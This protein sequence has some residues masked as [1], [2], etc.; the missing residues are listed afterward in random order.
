MSVT[1][2]DAPRTT[3]ENSITTLHDLP[4]TYLHDEV[5][6]ATTSF[7]SDPATANFALG[8]FC[9]GLEWDWQSSSGFSS[10]ID[11][12][13]HAK[14][15]PGPPPLSSDH[16]AAYALEQ[17]PD[18][19]KIVTPVDVPMF[20]HLLTN[21]PNRPF[22]NS[23]L[24]GLTEGFWPICDMPSAD[25]VDNCNHSVCDERPDVLL[26]TRDKEM[27]TGRYSQPFPPF[28]PGMKVSP[29][30]L[31]SKAGSSKPRLCTDMSFG[32]VSLNNL[33]R[34]E[35]A[36]VS[37]DSLASFGPYMLDVVKGD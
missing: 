5:V 8:C 13:L 34:K 36:R 18:T 24:R 12:S 32:P 15:L 2:L 31:A 11:A 28:L 35:D 10:A 14:P 29:L 22:V 26:A 6:R 30:L 4:P 37:Y 7:L 16:C 19:F 20:R 27:T 1:S 23:V 3:Q 25:T 17:Y 33:V 9:R 21:H